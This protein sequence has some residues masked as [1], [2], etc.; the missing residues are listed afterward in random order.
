MQSTTG[1]YY[2]I[3]GE[4]CVCMCIYIPQGSELKDSSEKFVP[5]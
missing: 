1:D 2:D 5:G 4:K 3:K